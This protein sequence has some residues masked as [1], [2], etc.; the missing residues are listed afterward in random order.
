MALNYLVFLQSYRDKSATTNPSLNIFK[1]ER[2]A[3]GIPTEKAESVEFDLAAGESR[4]LFSGTRTLNQ[5]NTTEYDIYLKSGTTNTYV[6]EYL[7][8]TAPDFRDPRSTGADA[9]T[10]V[11]VTKNATVTTLTSIGGTA[12][13]FLVGGVTVGD[14][15]STGTIFNSA[16]RG[17][18]QVIAVTA[19]SISF[20]NASSVAETVTLGADFL[21]EV[22]VYGAAGVQVG[23]VLRIF[24]GFSAVIQGNYS[25]TAVQDNLVEFYS[26]SALPAETAT[27]DSLVIYSAAKKLVYLETNERVSLIVNGTPESD[28]EPFNDNGCKANGMMLKK[29]T[30]WSLEVLNM[31]SDT[32]SLYFASVE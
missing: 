27:T 20:V 32:A 5:D 14:Y 22:R 17:R 6:L 12:F 21:N 31:G 24:G 11:Q 2:Q 8:G 28:I 13:D 19:T 18:Y 7:S 9:T 26:G 1:W 25:V 16:N 15:V 10:Q 23:D 29:S 3:Q 30:I 4:V